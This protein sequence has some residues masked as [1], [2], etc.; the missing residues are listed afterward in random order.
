MP[1]L[2]II[3]AFALASLRQW[4][5]RPIESLISVMLAIL[6]L[7]I[8]NQAFTVWLGNQVR[9]GL[10]ARDPAR[11]QPLLLELERLNVRV[12]RYDNEE[13]PAQHVR[14]GQLSAF[15]S[16]NGLDPVR[17]RVTLG[18][19]NPILDRELFGELSRIAQRLIQRETPAL[20]IEV[21]NDLYSAA[22][23]TAFITAG[24]VAFFVFTLCHTHV[25]SFWVR[26]W[27]RGTIHTL[28]ATPSPRLNFLAGRL[29]AG[30]LL[31]LLCLI[32]G[33]ALCRPLVNWPWPPRFA[34]W[35]GLILLQLFMGCGF[36]FALAALCRNYRF[37][38]NICSFLT[39]VLM[40][41]S[42]A[43]NPVEIMPDY[44]RLLAHLTPT[45]YAVR[46]MRAV[47]LGRE[48]LL[49]LDLWMLAGWGLAG[50]LIGYFAL[51]RTTIKK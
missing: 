3:F 37:Y 28:L 48:P 6:F 19:R 35:A 18:G 2:R 26:D 22:A 38:I 50:H 7:L 23:L 8:A 17:I 51:V 14:A 21:E 5:R 25:G 32:L 12:I 43:I 27:E 45:F 40:F 15:L 4:W 30:G 13:T 11:E 9:V 41:I 10:H 33:L 49:A 44:Q 31:I 34:P 42:G 16:V 36:F 1:S 47:M 29:L 20:R 39:V 24:M 46:S